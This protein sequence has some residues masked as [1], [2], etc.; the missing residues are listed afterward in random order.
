MPLETDA[1]FHGQ[2]ANKG[3]PVIG[4][5]YPE[6]GF[7]I[8]RCGNTELKVGYTL[9]THVHLQIDSDSPVFAQL[10]D[11]QKALYS[12]ACEASLGRK[13]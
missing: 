9:L 7:A 13:G 2:S 4:P 5:E 11:L 3:H 8:I 1:T 6:E 10:C 12:I